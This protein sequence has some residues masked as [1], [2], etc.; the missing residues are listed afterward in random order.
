MTVEFLDT[1]KA[2]R[3]VRRFLPRD[4]PDDVV[5]ELLEAGR[6]AP[7]AGNA[8]PFT[9]GVIKDGSTKAELAKAAGGQEWVATAPVVIAHCARLGADLADLP[10]DDIRKIID[11]ERFGGEIISYL[12]AYPDRRAVR[13]LL[14]N[15]AVMMPGEHVYLAAVSRGLSACWVGHLD[16]RAA[17]QILGLPD[18]M[19]CLFLMPIGYAAEEPP[20]RRTRTVEECVF[21]DRWTARA[22][23]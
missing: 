22:A 4:V 17:S 7:S 20:P 14:S 3:S 1:V 5:A 8:Q 19:A 9:F 11:T 16:T 21:Y 15:G 6:L 13:V 10:D 23:N 2:R 18:D 12:N